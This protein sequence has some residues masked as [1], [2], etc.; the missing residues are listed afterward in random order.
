M[1]ITG[2]IYNLY[3]TCEKIIIIIK[4]KLKK[5]KKTLLWEWPATP[6]LAIGVAQATPYGRLGGGLAIPI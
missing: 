6:I 1:R 5:K 3:A 4:K 2:S